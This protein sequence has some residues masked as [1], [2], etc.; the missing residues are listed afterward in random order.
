MPNPIAV[1]V[2]DDPQQAESSLSILEASRFDAR[3][4]ESIG[5]VLEYINTSSEL[6]DLFVLDRRLPVI[7]GQPASD[8]L[9][10]ELLRIVRSKYPDARLIV[11]TGFATIP[12]LQDA[13]QGGGQLP[14]QGSDPIDRVTV[15]QKNQSLEFKRHVEEYR[16]LLQDLEDVEVIF[17][18]SDGPDRLDNRALRRLAFEY[19]AVS[20]RVT[21]LAGGLTGA[22]VWRCELHRAEGHI[23]TVIA[24]R[25]NKATVPGGLPD[26]LPRGVTTSTT[27]T[28]SGLMAGSCLNVLQVAGPTTYSLMSVLGEDPTR[29]VDLARPVWDALRGIADQSRTLPVSEICVSLLAWDSLSDLLRKHGVEVPSGTL[30]ATVR[31]GAR[32]GDLHPGNI[33]IDNDQGVLIDFD[34]ATF[35]GAALD[36]VTMLIST[37]VHP[38]SPIRGASWPGP[39]EIAETFGTPDFGRGHPC[40]VWF[41]EVLAWAADSRASEREFWAL[42]LAYS[43][44]QLRYADVLS[45][46]D[47]VDR[48]VA[49]ARRATVVLSAS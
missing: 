3:S 14:A 8:E 38:D 29:A 10:D 24:K 46:A 26:L 30:T 6:V 36:P 41:R 22:K 13:L 16:K 2:E 25:V 39:I 11:F 42:V 28:L 5:P 47:T 48:V 35:A 49:I 37:L 9:G 23:A 1:L 18:E 27:A 20:I 45:N 33:L 15:L 40:E 17:L 44:R 4:F 43:A 12:H 31:V 32:H 19:R 7:A 34:S 21:P